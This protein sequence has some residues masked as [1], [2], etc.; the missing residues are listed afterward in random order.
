MARFQP[1]SSGVRIE[2]NHG[3]NDLVY[4]GILCRTCLDLVAFDIRPYPSSLGPGAANVKP[5]AIRC[6]RGHNH[7]YFPPDFRFISS[8]VP[9][10]DAAIQENRETYRALNP[11]SR[12]SYSDDRSPAEKTEALRR[13]VEIFG[14]GDDLPSD[15][16]NIV[17]ESNLDHK[18]MMV[19]LN[20]LRSEKRALLSG[21]PI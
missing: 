5:G 19:K 7:Y 15:E 16:W 17:R 6:G 13:E 20:A 21:V 14:E 18:T 8:A 3:D 1:N 10:N 11:S 9:I 12:V 2:L 4:W